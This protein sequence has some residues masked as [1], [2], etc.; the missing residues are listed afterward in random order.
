MMCLVLSC[1]DGVSSSG[2]DVSGVSTESSTVEVDSSS[3][4]LEENISSSSV[5]ESSSSKIQGDKSST[6]EEDVSSSSLQENISSSSKGTSSSSSLVV[7]KCKTTT[8][9]N[10]VYGELYDKRD[11]K[12]YKTVVMGTQEWMAENLNY[13]DSNYTPNLQG[14]LGAITMTP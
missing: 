2:E 5:Q 10:C 12:T 6:S 14:A 13:S 7:G 11:G 4:S 8:K 9:D 1:G 3:S